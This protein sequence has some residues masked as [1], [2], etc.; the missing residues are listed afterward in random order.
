MD[1]RPN[2]TFVGGQSIRVV[3]I[4]GGVAS[5]KSW[6]ARQLAHF[7]AVILD[8]DRAGHEVL[9]LPE[10]EAASRQRWGEAIFD[11]GGHIVRS[12]LAEIVFADPPEGPRE[13]HYLEQLTHP[14]IGR[15][16]KR[17]IDALVV[18]GARVALLDAALLLETG[19]GDLCDT[20]IFV[21]APRAVRQ[22]RAVARGWSE[23]E[24]AAREVVQES[25]DF[26]R[27]CADLVVD[28]S[29]PPDAI[30]AQLTRLWQS[31]IDC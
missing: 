28:N 16:L 12:R 14:E 7:G 19:W 27:E 25:L 3:G 10:I 20:L 2:V 17:Q 1:K 5:G 30:L 31:L 9:R 13:R 22:E 6:V 18:A 24:L 21:D 4:V 26:K 15:R 29:G 8:A 11:D 23:E